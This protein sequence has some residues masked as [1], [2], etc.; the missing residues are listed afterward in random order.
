[1]K[2]T[3]IYFIRHG[4]SK[5]NEQKLFL[6]NGN[7]D[8]TEKGVQQAM[9]TAAYLEDVPADFIYSSDLL[10][11]YHT[12]KC[13]ADLKGMQIITDKDLREI[14]G[15]KWEF[16]P[17]SSLSTDY[18][19]DFKVWNEDIGHACPT[20]GESVANLAER[21][22]KAVTAIAEK[23]PGCNIFIF[24][25]ATPIRTFYTLA[26]GKTL[27]DLKDIPWPTNASVTHASYKEGKFTVHAYSTDHFM[28]E[29]VTKLPDNI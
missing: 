1:M 28:K 18:P 20:G 17:F 14:N 19:E 11:A 3:N 16:S 5:A 15:G 8:L 26:T 29:L 27:S 2:E 10:R 25:H 9:M 12:A 4:E 7:L 6:G 23:H 22:I 24:S 21:F 13:T